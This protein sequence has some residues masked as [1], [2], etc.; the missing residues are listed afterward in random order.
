MRPIDK[1]PVPTDKDGQPIQLKKYQQSRGHLINRLGAYCSYCE[2]NLGGNIAVE[3]VKP[4]SMH[5]DLKLDWDNFLLACN[6]CNSIK[7]NK[8]VELDQFLWPDKDNTLLAFVYAS[9]GLIYV[10]PTLSPVLRQL[11]ENTIKLTGLDRIPSDELSEN[12]EM[13]DTRW[14]SRR[15]ALDKAERSYRHLMKND[16]EEM[17]VQ[18][19][20]TATSTG[21]FSIWMMVFQHD[22]DMR[23]RLFQAFPGTSTDSFN[24]NY[25]PINRIGG[26]I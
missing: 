2:R 15:T 23:Q 12:P 11:A 17:R 3:H 18:I 13:K 21:F 10:S 9:G 14:R 7:G 4:K 19:V 22:I 6:N 1:G 20:D 16:T 8:H 25:V 24:S 26:K 5:P